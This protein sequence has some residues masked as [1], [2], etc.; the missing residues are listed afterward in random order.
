[1][2]SGG[3]HVTLFL[4]KHGNDMIKH[5]HTPLLLSG[6]LA[7]LLFGWLLRAG[8]RPLAQATLS[9][10]STC[11]IFPADHIWNTA[12]D[13]LPLH[14]LS[15]TYLAAIGLDNTL[16]P[17]FGAGDWP[18]GSGSPIGIPYVVVEQGQPFVPIVFTA[19]GSESDPGPYPIPP[20]A[21]IEG[22]PAS[23][24]DR[25]VLVVDAGHCTLY[26]LYRA[27]PINSG[28]SWEADS[29]AIFNLSGYALRPAGWTSADAAG[30]PIFP[31]LVRYDEV[32]SGQINHALRFTAPQTQNSYLWPARHHAGSANPALPPM[33]LRLRLKASFDI[34]AYP[35]EVRVILQAMKTYGIILADN[36]SPWYISGAPDERWNNA[37]L[38][39]AFRTI[40]GR[41]FEAVDASLLMLHPDSGQTRPFQLEAAA[42]LPAIWRGP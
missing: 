31:G 22:G 30:L 15:A 26:E 6:L 8:Q 29:G 39:S 27:F 13:T 11:A 2:K 14:P 21:P 35:A 10:P 25:H 16:H 12:V 19:Y 32:Q 24:G 3:V 41:D 23:N 4:T 28:S 20:D 38:V 18:P 42:Y 7:A 37:A 33:G 40:R 17:D 1:L 34:T 5:K 36:G 9:S